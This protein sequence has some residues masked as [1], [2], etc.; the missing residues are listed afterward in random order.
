[1]FVADSWSTSHR[2][3]S[4]KYDKPTRSKNSCQDGKQEKYDGL[5]LMQLEGIPEN[6]W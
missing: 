4:M 1:M 3:N 6:R 5:S 2:V